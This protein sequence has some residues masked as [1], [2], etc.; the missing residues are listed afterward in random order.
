[1]IVTD[2]AHSTCRMHTNTQDQPLTV[3]GVGERSVL[4]AHR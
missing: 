3:R 2:R 4:P 1:M